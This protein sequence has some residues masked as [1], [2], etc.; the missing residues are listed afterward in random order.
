MLPVLLGEV[1]EVERVEWLN[2][3]VVARELLATTEAISLV[4]RRL[5]R[6]ARNDI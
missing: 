4:R 2:D 6:F 3:H 1:G 5:L